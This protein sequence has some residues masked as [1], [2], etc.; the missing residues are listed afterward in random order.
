MLFEFFKHLTTLNSGSIL[1]VLALAEKFVKQPYEARHLFHS[2]FLFGVS[3]STAL[4]AMAVLAFYA[5]G[6]K[7]SQFTVRLLAWGAFMSGL[8]FFGGI[9]LISIVVLRVLG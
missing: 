5:G 6:I 8:G 3:I 4:V 1:V 7:P 2:I 9:A